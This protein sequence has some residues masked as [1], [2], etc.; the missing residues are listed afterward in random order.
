VDRA[1]TF[2]TF[3]ERSPGDPFPRY[4]LAMELRNRGDRDGALAEFRVLL[5]RFAEYIPTYLMAGNTLVESGQLDE[6]RAVYARGIEAARGKGDHHA[7]RELDGA[8][9]AIS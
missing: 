2:R 9:A 8:L 3:I 6:A 7:A 4:G 5:E 1:A